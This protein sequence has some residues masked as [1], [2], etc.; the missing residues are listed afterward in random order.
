MN[1]AVNSVMRGNIGSDAVL[2]L[3]K[4]PLIALHKR[5]KSARLHWSTTGEKSDKKPGHRTLSSDSEK[6]KKKTCGID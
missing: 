6:K 3:F 5:V 4:I 2:G 1:T